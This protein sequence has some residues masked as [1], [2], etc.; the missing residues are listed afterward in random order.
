M[1]IRLRHLCKT[2]DF[3]NSHKNGLLNKQNSVRIWKQ[4]KQQY[5]AEVTWRHKRLSYS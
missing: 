1:N 4:I 5:L 2:F 3:Y